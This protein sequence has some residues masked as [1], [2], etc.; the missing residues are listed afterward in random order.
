MYFQQNT[1]KEIDHQGQR[2][3]RTTLDLPNFCRKQEKKE[4][5]QD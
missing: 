5:E 4:K 1:E 3:E 2:I